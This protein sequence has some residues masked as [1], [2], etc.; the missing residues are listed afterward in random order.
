[1]QHA[2]G[3]SALGTANPVAT[4]PPKV[5]AAQGHVSTVVLLG[6][7]FDP[8]TRHGAV[9]RI[10]QMVASR[11]PHYAI[12][13]N[14][15]LLAQARR[16]VELRHVLLGAHLV[17]CEGAP[18]VWASRLLG[19][20]LP[21][22]VAPADLAPLLIQL[23]VKKNYRL[24]L[25]GTSPEANARAVARLKSH[26]PAL[27]LVG[28]YSPPLESP[29]ENHQAEIKQRINAAR[30]DLLFVSFSC[31]KQR[32]WI[33][34]H[35]HA[36]DVPV[37]IGL[38]AAIDLFAG[39][40]KRAPHWMRRAGVEWIF[41]FL[42]E[43]C[44]RFRRYVGD[45]WHFGGAWL[46]QCWE[47]QWRRRGARRPTPSSVAMAE[48]K[49]QR[50]QVS[51]RLDVHS[52]RRDEA[53]WKQVRSHHG[54][55][56]LDLSCV[57]FIDS[58]GVGLL[59]RLQAQLRRAGHHLILVAPSVQVLRALRLLR[60]EEFFETAADAIEA[61]GIIVSR[62][63]DQSIPA[64]VRRATRPLAGPGEITAG[65]AERVWSVTEKPIKRFCARQRKIS[66]DLSN[67][68]FVAGTR[69]GV[70]FRAK[71]FAERCGGS[72][73]FAG[74]RPGARD[75]LRLSKHESGPPDNPA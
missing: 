23:A 53:V 45:L 19:N 75:V 57:R 41:R 70:T 66:I 14:S 26:R 42:Q 60:L 9:E 16:D 68:R 13:A 31:P 32:K 47:M 10:E 65:N 28:S 37:T 25:L 5:L 24:F 36:L 44:R 21:E 72:I 22:R 62:D 63:P 15:E 74:P 43:P 18:L 34:L 38:G 20:P 69:L 46:A 33:A 4:H 52:I 29:L 56:L 12:T 54:H 3:A 17:L 30:P 8:M 35:Y 40:V 50:V 11:Q 64:V 61:R 1:M 48:R 51:E 59:V 71:K 73:R 55:G 39:N 27:N 67:V 58:T 6:V 7:P 49:W 2:N